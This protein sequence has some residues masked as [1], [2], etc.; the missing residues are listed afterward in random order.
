MSRGEFGT[1]MLCL[2]E[3]GKPGDAGLLGHSGRRRIR[4]VGKSYV[5]V[6]LTTH[7]KEFRFYSECD[8]NFEWFKTEM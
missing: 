5:M 8:T 4:K 1:N 3:N 7:D 2:R 6:D